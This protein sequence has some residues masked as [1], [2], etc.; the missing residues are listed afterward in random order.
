MNSITINDCALTVKEYKGKRV[1]TFKDIDTVHGRPEGTARKRFN[2][3][4]ERF[5]E[6]TDYYKI[7][8]SEKRTV[9]IASNNGGT[10]LTESGYLMLVKAFTDD[11]AWEVQRQLVNSYFRL[12]KVMTDYQRMMSQT[13][14]ENA[15]IR[16]AQIL[17]KLADQYNGTYKQV[18]Q[19]Y[20]TKELTGDFLLPLPA[21]EQKTFSAA[22]I[23]ER[24]GISANMVGKLTNSNNLKTDQY[25]QWFHDKS[26]HSSK[27]VQTFRYYEN[28]VPVLQKLI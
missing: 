12:E 6:G 10:V 5:I 19:A 25:G 15:K 20:A 1:V 11:L 7:Q 2:D 17:T 24:L 9:E 28:V 8:P 3:N 23:G 4:R 18:L 13:R 21:I 14:A 26:R 22:E 27:E 16:K